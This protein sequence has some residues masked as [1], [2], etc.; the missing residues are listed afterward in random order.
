M[1]DFTT[2][3]PY[4]AVSSILTKDDAAAFKPTGLLCSVARYAAASGR[5]G[6]SE[7]VLDWRKPVAANWT[8]TYPASVQ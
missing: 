7:G 3:T 2:F 8:F 1:P 6:A 4:R 5:T